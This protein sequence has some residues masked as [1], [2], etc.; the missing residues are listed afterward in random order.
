[1]KLFDMV[2]PK[3]LFQGIPLRLHAPIQ[4][5]RTAAF[6]S[7]G[8]GH[9]MKTI[10]GVKVQAD[11][12]AQQGHGTPLTGKSIFPNML[13]FKILASLAIKSTG[14]LSSGY[15]SIFP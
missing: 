1:M 13:I 7:T 5:L 8:A 6:E 9:P 2:F 14:R 4:V 11:Q 12:V 15:D 10:T 3:G